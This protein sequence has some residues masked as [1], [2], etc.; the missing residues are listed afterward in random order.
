[1]ILRCEFAVLNGVTWARSW[2]DAFDPETFPD[3]I[4]VHSIE[5][6]TEPPPGVLHF[7]TVTTWTPLGATSRN[8]PRAPF[9]GAL[10]GL[11]LPIRPDVLIAPPKTRWGLIYCLHAPAERAQVLLCNMHVR[12]FPVVPIL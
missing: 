3:A 5:W 6:A 2:F 1:M 9:L 10:H 12:T 8:V 7:E 4:E 11:A